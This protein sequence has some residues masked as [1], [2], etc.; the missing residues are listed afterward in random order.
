[1]FC[2]TL[3]L[4][5][6]DRAAAAESD[7]E[8]QILRLY[9]KE[10]DLVISPT[11]HPKH[12]SQVAENITVVTAKEIEAMNAHTVA[13]VLNRVTGLLVNFNQDFGATSLIYSQGSEDRHVL[14]LV[15]G[16]T[17]NFLT[18][19][20]KIPCLKYLRILPR[21]LSNV[22][23]IPKLQRYLRKIMRISNTR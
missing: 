23:P 13:D 22:S 21:T 4:V 5:C 7:E 9:F 8:M 12:I 19:A 1:M 20:L 11:R 6:S 15:D 14:V 2:L 18:F 16:M 17:W 10:K 3:A